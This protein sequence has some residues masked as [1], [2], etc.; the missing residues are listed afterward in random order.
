M[1]YRPDIA[2]KRHDDGGRPARDPEKFGQS[3]GTGQA[4][5]D[6]SEDGCE[7]EEAHRRRGLAHGSA[8]TA[9]DGARRRR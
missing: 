3:E 1:R 4:L 5:W 2:R 7:V 6:H 8:H 9:L